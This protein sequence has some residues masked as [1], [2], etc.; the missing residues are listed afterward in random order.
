[1]DVQKTQRP[2]N[3]KN[4]KIIGTKAYKNT[5]AKL[6]IF[7]EEYAKHGRLLRA[8]KTAGLDFSI[9]YDRLKTDAI[10]REAFEV[11]EQRAAQDVEDR[12]YGWAM[13]DDLQA[14][15]VL[16]KRFRPQLYRERISAEITGDITISDMLIEARQRL[17]GIPND[18]TGTEG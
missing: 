12:V 18:R 2:V 13:D 15:V 16:L 4:P 8:C 9:H 1:M 10:Y 3:P 11:A 17:I 6:R 7:L 14:A 5:E